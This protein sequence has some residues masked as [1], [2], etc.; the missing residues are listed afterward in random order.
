MHYTYFEIENFKGIRKIRLD[1]SGPPLGRV[2]TLVG[3]NESGKTTL[4]EAIDLFTGGTEELDPS[5]LAGRLQPS[6]SNFVPIAKRAN[7]NDK[8]KIAAGLALDTNDVEAIRSILKNS[9]DSRL[10]DVVEELEVRDEYNF[11]NSKFVGKSTMYPGNLG[12]VVKGRRRTESKINGKSDPE[13]WKAIVTYIKAHM[14]PI[15]YFPNFLFDFPDRIYLREQANESNTDRFYRTILQDVLDS[16]E[17]GV[18]VAE[19]LL[20]RSSSTDP[21][22]KKALESLVLQMSRKLSGD[23]FSAWKNVLRN[24][25]NMK[26]VLNLDADQVPLHATTPGE[27]Y[28]KVQIEADDGMFE[29]NERSLGFRWFFVFILLT[30]FRRSRRDEASE[31]LYLFDEPASNLHSSAQAQLLESLARLADSRVRIVYTTHSHHLIN[32]DWLEQTFVV[33]NRGADPKNDLLGA[34]AAGTDIAID[35]YRAFSSQHPDQAQYFQPI[36]DVLDYQPSRLEMVEKLVLLEGKNDF[37]TLR[38]ALQSHPELDLHLYPGGG[39]GSLDPVIALYLAWARD[40]IVLLDSDTEG[41]NQM[42]RYQERFGDVVNNRI[43]LLS[44]LEPSMSGKSLDKVFTK[45]DRAGVIAA[46]AGVGTVDTKSSFH[47]CLQEA[48]A[49]KTNVALEADTVTTLDHLILG[50]AARLLAVAQEDVSGA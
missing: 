27:P 1:L 31:L 39:A 47:R 7:F 6:E 38:L 2:F 21:A 5:L 26:V 35:K 4:L 49:S 32:P 22:D 41:A 9:Y 46:F 15:W 14:P 29:I 10:V 34:T 50:I 11:S 48:V 18:N 42:A 25:L 12:T 20:D 36:L 16:L 37:Y 30:T 28:I 40:F 33:R 17:L 24:Q 23:V 13:L 44:D 45:Q 3:L 19:H 8:I 43:F